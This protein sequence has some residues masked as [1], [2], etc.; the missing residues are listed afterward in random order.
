MGLIW[1]IHIQFAHSPSA[2]DF[3]HACFYSTLYVGSD[4]TV[5]CPSIIHDIKTEY[6]KVKREFDSVC[7]TQG[8]PTL[9][10]VKDLCLDLIACVFK[11]IRT[12]SQSPR[13]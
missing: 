13:R 3:L 10:Q 6:M 7:K 1:L 5:E 9:E 8:E 2:D 4:A 11:D 12:S